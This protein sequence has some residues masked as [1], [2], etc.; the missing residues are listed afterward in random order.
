MPTFSTSPLK[1]V[2]AVLLVASLVEG[3]LASAQTQREDLP[4]DLLMGGNSR[5]AYQDDGRIYWLGFQAYLAKDGLQS[6]DPLTDTTYGVGVGLAIPVMMDLY[7]GLGLRVLVAGSYSADPPFDDVVTHIQY[8]TP[9]DPATA[10]PEE[11]VTK[12]LGGYFASGTLGVGLNYSRPIMEG[13]LVPY[14]GAGPAFMLVAVFPDLTVNE[15][16]LLVNEYNDITDPDNVDP[17]SVSTV[18][19]FHGYLGAEIRMTR[20]L[21]L[22]VEVAYNQASI[23]ET[24]L[25]K[26]TDGYDARR[27]AFAYGALNFG[28]GLSWHF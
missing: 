9:A 19:G 25:D 21:H 17:Y 22:N 14:V 7:H 23:P 6:L 1:M 2:S 18:V 5:S 28:T 11:V 8:T 15:S 3:G 27:L 26:S 12:Q 4:E 13:T 10:T 24:H 16:M 20:A